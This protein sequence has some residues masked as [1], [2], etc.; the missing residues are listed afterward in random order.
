MKYYELKLQTKLKS[1]IHFQ[2]SPEAISKMIATSLINSGYELHNKQII[3]NYVFSNLG[4]A[5]KNGFFSRGEIFI[6]S[7][8][9]DIIQKLSN[10][11]F[12][13]DNIFKVKNLSFRE[14]KYRKINYILSL[15]PVFVVRDNEF[16]TFEKN[17]DL[18]SLMDALQDNLIRKYEINFNEKLEPFENFIEFFEIKNQKPQ[19][20]FYKGIKFFGNKFFIRIKSDEISQKL[21]FTSIATGLGHK[22]SSVGGGFVKWG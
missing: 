9:R 12:Y 3:K 10:L 14:V 13:E 15:N 4:K 16:W 5:D 18:I 21:A 20:F 2:K 17:G 22:N 11:M 19:T 1:K 6:R 7:F 8:S